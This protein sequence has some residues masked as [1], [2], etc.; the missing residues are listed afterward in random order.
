V[1]EEGG[2][3]SSDG[4]TAGYRWFVDPLDGTTNFAHRLPIFSVSLALAGGDGL[5][6][7]GVV[8]DVMRRECFAAAKGRGATLNGQPIHVSDTPTLA[9]SMMITGFP[10]DRWTDPE[11][12]IEHWGNFVLRAQGERCMGS[13]ALDL[14]Y[15]AAGRGDGYWESK[16]HPWDIM[17]GALL[18][19]EAGG[20]VTDYL[21][22]PDVFSP[23]RPKV[24]ASN[25]HIH[26]EMLQVLAL[27]KDAPRPGI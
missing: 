9:V 6:L 2:S 23:K 7:V 11:N 21:G 10:Y 8:Y 17:A 25:G 5:P 20:R 16:L 14:A 13:A 22:N 1:G 18:V 19:T 3:Y 24:V 12:N 15:I 27:G 4:A 26:D